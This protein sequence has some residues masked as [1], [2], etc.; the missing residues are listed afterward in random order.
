MSYSI[1]VAAYVLS[2]LV[3]EDIECYVCLQKIRNVEQLDHDLHPVVGYLDLQG[4]SCGH[5]LHRRVIKI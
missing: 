3:N 5:L 2:A 4:D 1:D